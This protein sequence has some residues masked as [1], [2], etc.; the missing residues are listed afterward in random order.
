MRASTAKARTLVALIAVVAWFGVFLQLYLS[1]RLTDAMGMGTSL[2][3]AIYLGYFTVLTNLLVGVAA[4]LPLLV[5]SSAAAG[6]FVRPATVGWVTASIAFVGMAY[7]VL[8]RHVWNPQGLQLL[9]D[10]LMHYVVPALCV[11]YSV[12]ALRRAPLRW[13]LPLWWSLYPAAYFF[14]VLVR[15]VAIGHYPYRFVDVSQLGYALVLR[16]AV[17]LLAAFLGLSYVLM[18]VWRRLR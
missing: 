3:L 8:L 13:T 10:V 4:A 16:N 14:Y 15:G 1:L 5:P 17:V 2:G 9:A 18:L 11:I 7:F 12:I 6:F